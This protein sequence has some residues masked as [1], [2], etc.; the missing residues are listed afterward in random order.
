MLALVPAGGGHQSLARAISE[1]LLE[2]EPDVTV[3]A[4]NLCS[5]E[6]G[7]FPLAAVPRLYAVVTINLPPVWRALFHATSGRRRY[8]LIERVIEP[9][10]GPRLKAVLHSN[11]PDVIVS[12][13][14]V[15]GSLMQSSADPRTGGTVTWPLHLRAR[16]ARVELVHAFGLPTLAGAGGTD[17]STAGGW[18]SKQR[19][20]VSSSICPPF[21]HIHG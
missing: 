21:C 5:A 12:L 8:A 3:S 10:V 1:A 14:P 11:R 16:S 6:C 17:A 13:N 2:L 19:L 18:S 9:F 7:T 4:V 15:L 20:R